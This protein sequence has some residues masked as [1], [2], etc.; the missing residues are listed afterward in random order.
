MSGGE[1]PRLGEEQRQLL[2]E[3]H[4]RLFEPMRR[5]AVHALPPSNRASAEDVV[6]TVFAE[7]ASAML[8]RPRLRIGDGWLFTR[9]RSRIVDCHRHSAR[10]RR[11]MLAVVTIDAP[12]SAEELVVDRAAVDGLLAAIPDPDDQL[13]LAFRLFGYT[14]AEIAARMSLSYERRQVRERLRK[15]RRRAVVW[16]AAEGWTIAGASAAQPAVEGPAA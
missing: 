8:E 2:A 11:L 1:R 5:M 15:V 13:T 12:V 6:Q 14:E 7:A 3:L 10:Q 4:A 9:L 16:R